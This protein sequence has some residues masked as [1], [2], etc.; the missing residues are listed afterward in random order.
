VP[1]EG[2]QVYLVGAGPGHPELLTVRAL[3]CLGRADVVLYDQLVP[4]RIVDLARPG[5]EKICVSELAATHTERGPHVHEMLIGAARQG[6]CVVRLKGGDPMIFGRG[7]E[8]A[9]ALAEAG[10]AFEIVPGVSAANGASAYAGMPL[11]HRQYASAV[12]LVAGHEDPIKGQ[13]VIDWPALVRF[14]GTLA[15]YMGMRRLAEISDALLKAGMPADTPAAVIQSATTGQQR[16]VR[17]MLGNIAQQASQ[18]ELASPSMVLIGETVRLGDKLDWAGRRPL[19]GKRVI[20]TR[21]RQQAGALAAR[22]EE[23]GALTEIIPLLDIREP[24][25]WRPVDR[26][27]SRLESFHYLV[28]T[29][30]NGVQAFMRR[31]LIAGRDLRALGSL[32]LAAIGPGT[33]AA[34]AS[35]CLHADI[36]PSE[37]RSEGLVDIL[38]DRAIGKRILLAR[39]DRGRDVL[40]RELSAVA[41]VVQV[42]VYS[43]VDLPAGAGRINDLVRQGGTDYMTVTS[44]NIARALARGLDESARVRMHRG[45]TSLI[46]ISPVTSETLR[47]VGL[48][49][50]AEAKDYTMPGV[51]EALLQLDRKAKTCEASKH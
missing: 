19:R 24:D 16:T 50:A 4:Q 14:P 7:G 42:T 45:D 3:H 25:D 1:A 18:A 26:A 29:S 44:S 38:R 21:P 28:F 34:L 22:L 17:A 36:V 37:Y 12:A 47:D 51:V 41:E 27:L 46:S 9:E 40:A 32:Q 8:E 23:L 49:V 13:S 11:T 20:V 6:K 43:Q 10:I 31:L 39:A 48:P 5:A 30:A 15:I 33:A 35:F 2:P